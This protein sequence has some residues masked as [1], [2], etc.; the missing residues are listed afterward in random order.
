MRAVRRRLQRQLRR[1][2]LVLLRDEH[3][4]DP[5]DVLLTPRVVLLELG[6]Q[7]IAIV[8]APIAPKVGKLV[9]RGGLHPPGA[10][11]LARLFHPAPSAALH[12]P[13]KDTPQFLR[14]PR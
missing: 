7:P 1:E 9:E 6:A 2:D 8:E 11:E 4:P 14:H 3:G 10:P 13:V 12:A 5:R